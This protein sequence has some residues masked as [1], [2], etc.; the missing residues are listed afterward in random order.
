MSGN[1]FEE[2]LTNVGSA[3]EKYLGPD[4][5]YYK[6][7]KTPGEIGMSNKGSL[8]QLGKDIDGLISYVEV[9]VSGKSKASK[10]GKPLGNK[11]FLKTGGKCIDRKTD[12]EVDRYIYINNVPQGNIP[13]MPSGFNVNF[14]EFRGLIPGTISQLDAFNPLTIFQSFLMGSKPECQEL[15]METIDINNNRSTETNYVTLVDIRNM[16]PCLFQNKRNPVTGDR[17]RETFQN[18]EEIDIPRIPDDILTKLY[19]A[20]LGGLGIYLLYRTMLKLKMIPK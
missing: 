16:N 14:K 20:S 7:I 6:Y 11:F 3:K 2:V 10:T 5:P 13:F 8:T 9:L 1:I 4:Y 15:T 19:F 12:E 17:C 18:M